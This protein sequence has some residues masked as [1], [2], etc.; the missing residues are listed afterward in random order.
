MLVWGGLERTGGPD[1]A[2]CGGDGVGDLSGRGGRSVVLELEL[3]VVLSS[4]A[5]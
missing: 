2:I 3:V 4:E 1:N 5:P